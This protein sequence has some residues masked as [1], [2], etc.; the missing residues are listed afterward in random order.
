MDIARTIQT[1]RVWIL[2]AFQVCLGLLALR[3]VQLQV[4]R[5]RP[6]LALAER[7]EN[8]TIELMPQRGLILDCKGR[9][10][11]I[12]VSAPSVAIN[13]RKIPAADRAQVAARLAEILHLDAAEL[14]QRLARPLYF[15]W[16]K[17]QA[18]ES[19]ARAVVEAGIPGIEIRPEPVR[20]YPGGSFLS[21]V[22]GGVGIDGRGLE[23]VE[24]QFDAAL[25]G[26]PGEEAV[27]R[28][29]RGRPVGD[30]DFP[31]RDPVHGQSVVLTIDARIQRI[32]EE[33]LAAACEKYHPESASAIVMDPWTGDVLAM[34]SW[35]SFDPAHLGRVPAA[36]R[37]NMA[38]VEMVEPGSTFKPFVAALAL[39]AGLVRP[40]SIFDCHLGAYRI[41]G[42]TL[43]DVHPY[44]R[45]TVREIIAYSSNIGMAQ[46]GARLGPDRMYAGLRAM[47]F[48]QRS[49]IELS[50]ESTG[51][52]HHPRSWSKLTI[53]SI[54]MG[55][56]VAVSPLQLTAGFCV[57]ANGGWHVQPRIVRGL[58]DHDGQRLLRAPEPPRFR[59]VLRPETANLMCKDLLAGVV[60]YGTAQNCAIDGYRMSG[61]T[62]TAQLARADARGYEPGSY[63]AAFG[64]ILPTDQPRYVITLL[65]RRPRGGAYYGGVVAAPAAARMGERI[66]SMFH[67]P[68]TASV[69]RADAARARGGRH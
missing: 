18:G 63:L 57:F 3:L 51:L 10:L 55:Q 35:P 20:R 28:D 16:V 25:R 17:R 52:L 12:T 24:A 33:E 44:G 47:G 54:P 50:G 34:A 67:V 29:G 4:V 6:L 27:L 45:L 15:A 65:A 61:K 36:V 14:E 22:L 13:P 46:V 37:R 32:V 68:R 60:E 5:H 9:E 40:E 59:Q 31:R 53:S 2:A 23:G 48:G 38:V 58:A 43:H 42:R 19:E 62:G 11:A 56:E 26:V 30:P 1:R 69:A 21:H 41:G 8:A 66:L 64:A 7:M 39:D 49:G